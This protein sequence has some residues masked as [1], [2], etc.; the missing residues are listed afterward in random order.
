MIKELRCDY[1]L[2]VLC[3]VLSVSTSGYQAW[4]TRQPSKRA[5]SRERLCVAA[6]A[7]H[8]RTRATYGAV[9]LQQ[10][11]ASD[12]FRVSLGSIKRVRREL[13]LRC[14]QQKKCFRIT[15]TDSR[16]TLPVAP[17]LLEQRF[18]ATRP[19]EVWTA[20]ITYVPTD[21]GWL[22]VAAIKDLFAGEIVGRSFGSRMTTDLVV[23]ALQQ[24]V[25]VRR[26]AVGLI[27][28]TGSRVA[29][30]QP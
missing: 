24:A 18:T 28:Q 22:Y 20:D 13:G 29:V 11:L 1:P 9:R 25:A 26:P 30:L 12:G 10:E 14:V 19:N 7:A 2:A 3:R 4:S 6:Q 27:H 17:N 15:T 5:L 21:E 16:H 8:R 23:R